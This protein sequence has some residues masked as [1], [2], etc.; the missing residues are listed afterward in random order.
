RVED[1][2]GNVLGT[3]G[4]FT[5]NISNGGAACSYPTCPP[6]IIGTQAA[7]NLFTFTFDKIVDGQVGRV[8]LPIAG[9]RVCF[10]SGSSVVDCVA[11]GTYNCTAPGCL[12]A[13]QL[14]TGDGSA[15]GCDTN[16]GA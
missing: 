8:A 2:G 15:N 14:R 6:F 16:W 1:A 5:A 13:N 12:G 11:W 3:F 10:V 9:G 7:K 4:S